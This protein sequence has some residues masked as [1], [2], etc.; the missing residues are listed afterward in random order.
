MLILCNIFVNNFDKYH[1]FFYY[2]INIKLMVHRQFISKCSHAAST[3]Y[4]PYNAFHSFS[5]S[6]LASAIA[7]F[8]STNELSQSERREDSL[9][10]RGQ[11]SD[12]QN[13][14]S[15][16]PSV[17]PVQQNALGEFLMFVRTRH[18]RSE[19]ILIILPDHDSGLVG[20]VVLGVHL[21][22]K[23]CQTVWIK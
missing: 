16:S 7:T 22:D 14:A 5:E 1:N 18:F 23:Y 13:S 12:L 8:D 9:N 20:V 6:S 2:R 17:R 11:H 10:R 3:P 21:L 19:V 4:Y 15:S